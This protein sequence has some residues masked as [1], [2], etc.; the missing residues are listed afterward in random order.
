MTEDILCP[1]CL[2]KLESVNQIIITDK[3]YELALILISGGLMSGDP[4]DGTLQAKMLDILF[5]KVQEYEKKM[6]PDL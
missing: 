4:K 2:Q 6:F 1:C 5:D 3:N